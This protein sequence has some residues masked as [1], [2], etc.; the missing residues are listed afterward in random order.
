MNVKKVISFVP[1]E[2]VQ[3]KLK[4]NLKLRLNQVTY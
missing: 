4:G 1:R 3:I 2:L